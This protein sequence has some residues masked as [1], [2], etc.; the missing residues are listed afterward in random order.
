MKNQQAHTEQKEKKFHITLNT[1]ILTLGLLVSLFLLSQSLDNRKQDKIKAEK[2]LTLSETPV[3]PIKKAESFIA[4][5]KKLPAI[6]NAENRKNRETFFKTANSMIEDGDLSAFEY[7]WIKK[8]HHQLQEE[9]V[10]LA[11]Q[12]ATPPPKQSIIPLETK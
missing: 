2:A 11:P 4:N 8:A 1:V 9:T 6:D 12:K 5:I 3:D 7:N 10:E